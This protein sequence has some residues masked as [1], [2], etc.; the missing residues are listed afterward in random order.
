LSRQRRHSY[1]EE[2]VRALVEFYEH[3]RELALDPNRDWFATRIDLDAALEQL[4]AK[5]WE[6]VLLH[7]LIGFSLI[8]T[9]Q[10][11]QISHQAVSKRYRHGLDEVTYIIN[12][13]T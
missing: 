8:E 7:G 11:L 1:T 9:A 5:F 12:G 6:A 10:L 13:G 4:P 3:L 2:E